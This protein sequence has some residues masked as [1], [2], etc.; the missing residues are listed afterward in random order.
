MSEY[1]SIKGIQT[2]M[3]HPFLC[4]WDC[5]SVNVK[6]DSHSSSFFFAWEF[7]PFYFFPSFL[8]L[9]PPHPVSSFHFLF[10]FLFLFLLFLLLFFT[11]SSSS[12]FRRLSQSV[13][14]KMD[15]NQKKF[16][17]IKKKISKRRRKRLKSYLSCKCKI[18]NSVVSNLLVAHMLEF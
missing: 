13:F 2:K 16:V 11:F 3:P 6:R 1:D 15:K 17:R 5:F 12:T 18:M 9:F 7:P 8:F 10:L 14:E 4:W